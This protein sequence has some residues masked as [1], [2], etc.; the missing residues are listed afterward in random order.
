MVFPEPGPPMTR[1]TLP[2]GKPPLIISSSPSTPVGTLSDTSV[3]FA[4]FRSQVDIYN[5]RLTAPCAA[6]AS[7]FAFFG[8]LFSRVADV[9][10]C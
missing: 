4:V 8:G 1:T 3:T 5:L 9:R 6:G 10:G 7:V 2:L